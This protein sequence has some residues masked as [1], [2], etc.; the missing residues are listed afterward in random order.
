MP[1][2]RLAERLLI[3]AV[4]VLVRVTLLFVDAVVKA[5]LV[6]ANEGQ[7]VFPFQS[8]VPAI[9]PFGSQYSPLM[10]EDGL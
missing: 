10:D 6:G 3:V 5:R 9:V 1:V 2:C 7:I 4:P 8:V